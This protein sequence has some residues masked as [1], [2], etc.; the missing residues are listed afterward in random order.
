M[1]IP[2]FTG[3]LGDW[4]L[5]QYII[6]HRVVFSNEWFN[7]LYSRGT[8]ILWVGGMT[9][10]VCSC[11]GHPGPRRWQTKSNPAEQQRWQ[12]SYSLVVVRL[13]WVRQGLI[14]FRG[15]MKVVALPFCHYARFNVACM[16]TCL[17]IMHLA[18]LVEHR[19]SQAIRTEN[20]KHLGHIYIYSLFEHH[21]FPSVPLNC[22]TS[23][24][25]DCRAWMAATGCSQHDLI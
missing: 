18:N 2:L 16:L 12:E 5:S 3:E 8:W 13:M 20:M 15:W 11:C 23:E 6:W 22:A 19:L 21:L 14:L 10:S 24:P 9:V 1:I 17:D 25:C 4:S 7:Y